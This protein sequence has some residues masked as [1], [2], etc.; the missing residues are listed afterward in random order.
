MFY[1][2][3]C[4]S[5]S[6]YSYIPPLIRAEMNRCSM[7]N[8]SVSVLSLWL[9]PF[10]SY[11]P[12]PES[13]VKK[14]K[15]RSEIYSYKQLYKNPCVSS[16]KVKQTMKGILCYSESIYVHFKL[17]ESLLQELWIFFASIY[18]LRKYVYN[19]SD[20]ENRMSLA[21]RTSNAFAMWLKTFALLITRNYCTN[22]GHLHVRV[23][24]RC[25]Y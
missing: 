12:F 1:K 3:A 22:I 2:R 16:T 24:C 7:W 13:Y 10:K 8:R 20:L 23:E 17:S 18:T 19:Y 15:W 21:S 4:G 5:E 11:D 6:H 9:Q 25:M 14:G